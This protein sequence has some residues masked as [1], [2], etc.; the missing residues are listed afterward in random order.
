MKKFL[1]VFFCFTCFLTVPLKSY[2]EASNEDLV[3]LFYLASK[4]GDT[5]L[6]NEVIQTI[7]DQ[8]NNNGILLDALAKYNEKGK[9]DFALHNAIE[10]KNI[11]ASIILTHYAKDVNTSKGSENIYFS[12]N[13]GSSRGAKTPI[14]LVFKADMKGLIP[15]LPNEKS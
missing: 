1:F 14:E 13:P 5:K 12:A 8:E 6:I 3:E 7:L 15:Y 2:C 4:T 10:D 9:L 11:L